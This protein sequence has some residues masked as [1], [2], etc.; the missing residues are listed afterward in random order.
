MDRLEKEKLE[1]RRQEMSLKT[2]YFNRF[3]LIRYITAGFFFVNLYWFFSLIMSNTI[4]VLVPGVNLVFI[5]IAAFEQCAMVSS[6]IDNAKKTILTYKEILIVNILLIVALFTPLFNDLFPFLTK[7]IKSY[8]LILG[9][10]IIGIIFCSISL[11]RLEKIKNRTDKQFNYV[12]K[13]EQAI[14]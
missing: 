4:W 12:K 11:K 7:S 5:T 13:Y 8:C 2:M 10:V 3:L 6:P 9:I 1:K 14:K